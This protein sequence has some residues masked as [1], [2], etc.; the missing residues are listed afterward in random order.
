MK[1]LLII[2][3]FGDNF[4]RIYSSRK[5]LLFMLCKKTLI[6]ET[7]NQVAKSFLVNTDIPTRLKR[8]LVIE[9]INWLRAG[10]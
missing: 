7:R 3:S 8:K 1:R 5:E 6:K 10:L 4:L 2:A 9:Q